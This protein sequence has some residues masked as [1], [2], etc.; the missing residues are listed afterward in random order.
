MHAK[1]RKFARRRILVSAAY[2][3]DPDARTYL[4]PVFHLAGDDASAATNAPFQI[5]DQ[6]KPFIHRSTL[7]SVSSQ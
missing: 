3:F 1:K 4:Q 2:G 7:L 5:N 6:S